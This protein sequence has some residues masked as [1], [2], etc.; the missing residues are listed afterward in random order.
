MSANASGRVQCAACSREH[1]S[2]PDA[3]YQGV[4]PARPRS[5][6]PRCPVSGCDY[7]AG[8]ACTN[9]LCPG[10]HP[11][12]SRPV[13]HLTDRTSSGGNGHSAFPASVVGTG[14]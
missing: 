11:R 12:S 14:A 2:H 8:T 4:I 5:A 7:P 3:I 6:R 1:C 9:A 10:R 13:S